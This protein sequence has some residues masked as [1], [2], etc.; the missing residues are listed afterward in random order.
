MRIYNKLVRDN[1]P[2]IIK[3]TG[4][5]AHIR[6]LNDDEYIPELEKKLQEEVNEYLE[7]RDITELADVLEVIEALAKVHGRSLD[8]I[9]K[10]KKA[11]CVKNGAFNDKIF[12]IEVE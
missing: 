6:M 7:S 3:S 12:L 8:D 9:L 4:E 10:I 11:K 2:D 5:T 1:I